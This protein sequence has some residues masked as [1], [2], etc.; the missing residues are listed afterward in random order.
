MMFY[1]IPSVA[2]V[3]NYL[4]IGGCHLTIKEIARLSGKSS[5]TLNTQLQSF[6]KCLKSDF[7][8]DNIAIFKPF[9]RSFDEV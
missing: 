6:R 7:A 3:K 9:L 8:H 4:L 5:A 2:E 1:R